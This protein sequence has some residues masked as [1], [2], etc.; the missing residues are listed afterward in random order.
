REVE[1]TDSGVIEHYGY[2][3]DDAGCDGYGGFYTWDE[4]TQYGNLPRGIC[5]EGWKIP[6][7]AEYDSIGASSAYE[8][9]LEGEHASA[10]NIFG[11]NGRL[12][13]RHDFGGALCCRG[14]YGYHWTTDC[15]EY[16]NCK[17]WKMYDGGGIDSPY[18]LTNNYAVV[19][20]CIKD[21]L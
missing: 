9:L 16:P 1:Q 19:V 13:G 14:S 12:P 11:F 10:T 5:P 17:S 18:I 6:S 2:G 8:M 20:R 3:D 15:P 21:A 7:L 4:A